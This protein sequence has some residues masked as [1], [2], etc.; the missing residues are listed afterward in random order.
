MKKQTYLISGMIVLVALM[1]LIA[2][3][4]QGN[5]TSGMTSAFSVVDIAPSGFT[6]QEPDDLSKEAAEEAIKKAEL[7]IGDMKDLNFPVLFPNDALKEAKNSFDDGD[8]EQVFKV[9]QLI[10]YTKR[11]K[12]D[13]MDK[14]RLLE[15]KKQVVEDKG[16]N[17]KKIDTM[18]QQSMNAFSLEQFEDANEMLDKAKDEINKANV[19]RIRLST[20]AML[21]KNFFVRNWLLVLIIILIIALITPTI[22]T[23]FRKSH[24]K[25]KIKSLNL[26]LKKT[27]QLIKALQKECFI[28][29]KIN[30][31]TYHDRVLKYEER[32]AEIKHSVPIL[33]ARLARESFSYWGK[34]KGLFRRKGKNVVAKKSEVV[35]KKKANGWNHNNNK[36]TKKKVVKKK[37]T[38]KSKKK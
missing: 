11:Q 3:L 1:G 38:K 19:E 20:V 12:I 16:M 6:Y 15:I 13:F 37:V 29:H 2:V 31:D 23:K 4:Q 32:I 34:I 7:E 26:D 9:T 5:V 28:G 8:Y 10:S 36:K 17:M 24:L 25:R 35:T 18:M 33:E 14:M 22:F 27:N 21:G 30:T